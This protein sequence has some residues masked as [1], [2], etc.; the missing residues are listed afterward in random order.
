MSQITPFDWLNSIN[1][2]TDV[3][4]VECKTYNPFIVN[5]GLSYF[6]D[7]ILWA[8][9]MNQKNF[10]DKDIQYSFLN[11]TINK[12]KRFSK[13][14][15]AEKDDDI[16]VVQNTYKVSRQRAIEILTLLDKEK[17]NILKERQYKGGKG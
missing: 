2:K 6:R 11:K 9:E 16:E 1:L 7:T 12:K 4:D 5:R 15:K 17:L 3:D 10:L 8:N 14:F 13:W